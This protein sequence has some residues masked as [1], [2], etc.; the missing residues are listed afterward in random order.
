MAWVTANLHSGLVHTAR[1]ARAPT[2]LDAPRGRPR[3]IVMRQVHAQA[4][5]LTRAFHYTEQ[6]ANTPE[7]HRHPAAERPFA[8]APFQIDRGT[9]TSFDG[10][11][12]RSALAGEVKV[13]PTA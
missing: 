3:D 1:F 8:D 11:S 10:H 9:A 7:P 5:S 4:A 13:A 12:P 2:S 6:K